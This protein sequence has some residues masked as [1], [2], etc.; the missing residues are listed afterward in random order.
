[1]KFPVTL[2]IVFASVTFAADPNMPSGTADSMSTDMPEL[3]S[4]KDCAAKCGSETELGS[5]ASCIQDKCATVLQ[6]LSAEA[7]PTSSNVP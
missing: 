5:A 1:M 6:S 2:V 4:L 3:S 7:T